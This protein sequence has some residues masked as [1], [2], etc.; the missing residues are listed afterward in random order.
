MLT[1]AS[2]EVEAVRYSEEEP[3]PQP[4]PCQLQRSLLPCFK[5]SSRASERVS[6]LIG[7]GWTGPNTRE[8]MD[9]LSP[10]TSL[11]AEEEMP[12]R[13]ARSDNAA[14]CCR[15]PTHNILC[16][17]TTRRSVLQ[18][19]RGRLIQRD[20]ILRWENPPLLNSTLGNT[21]CSTKGLAPTWRVWCIIYLGA[22]SVQE[23]SVCKGRVDRTKVPLSL[24]K[25][26][27]HSKHLIT[28]AHRINLCYSITERDQIIIQHQHERHHFDY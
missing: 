1:W 10:I 12:D 24:L 18:I 14:V 19:E 2:R 27:G 7:R 3:E 17:N 16:L 8:A 26:Q 23:G 28:S 13:P 9:Y 5:W 20:E 22:S 21:W 15:R 6:D 25:L 4:G 11:H